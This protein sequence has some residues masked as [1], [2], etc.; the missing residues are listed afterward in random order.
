MLLPKQSIGKGHGHQNAGKP[1]SP[2]F[3]GRDLQSAM[4]HAPTIRVIHI[5]APK[6]IKTDVANFRSTVQKLTGRG[7]T[8]SRRSSRPSNKEQPE[9]SEPVVHAAP[10][11]GLFWDQQAELQRMVGDACGDHLMRCDSVDSAT[12]S[13]DSGNTDSTSAGTSTSPHTM[14]HH[15]GG[16]SFYPQRETPYSLS[17]IPAP[18]F[19]GE[20][21]SCSVPHFGMIN[22]HPL[23]GLPTSHLMD[24][25]LFD[26]GLIAPLPMFSNA[27]CNSSSSSGSLFDL[28]PHQHCRSSVQS[29]YQGTNSIFNL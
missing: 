1:A 27:P 13:L 25:P 3:R 17:E 19:G 2:P 8:K 28:M 24:Q 15:H 12:Y 20:M 26:E 29:P 14:D 9:L 10:A 11:A 18:F 6:V 16:F 7:K 22:S 5:F 21:P 23:M 4:Q